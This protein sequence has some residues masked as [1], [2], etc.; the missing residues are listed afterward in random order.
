M[1]QLIF[2]MNADAKSGDTIA[3]NIFRGA[4]PEWQ[5]IELV[6][7]VDNATENILQASV[8]EVALED[9]WVHYHFPST[10]EYC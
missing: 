8:F 3:L 6:F 7:L 2:L 5:E 4:G 1:Y 10:L 9:R